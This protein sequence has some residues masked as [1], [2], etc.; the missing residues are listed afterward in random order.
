MRRI[1]TNGRTYCYEFEQSLTEQQ[2]VI[3]DAFISLPPSQ[4][5]TPLGRAYHAGLAGKSLPRWGQGEGR[6]ELSLAGLD[7]AAWRAG[8]NIFFQGARP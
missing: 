8:R 1:V 4:D 7:V 5:I 6:R 3:Y 2:R